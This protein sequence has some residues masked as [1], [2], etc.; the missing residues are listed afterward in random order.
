MFEFVYIMAFFGGICFLFG[1]VYPVAAILCFPI[2]RA[3]GGRQ[4]LWDYICS[5]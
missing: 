4:C 1:V 2:Y 3:L 5:L